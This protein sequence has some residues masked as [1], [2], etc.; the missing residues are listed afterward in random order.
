MQ[1]D[2]VVPKVVARSLW[3]TPCYLWQFSPSARDFS[4]LASL[5]LG[6]IPSAR[7][8]LLL[9]RLQLDLVLS[10]KHKSFLEAWQVYM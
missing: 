2:S 5:V 3:Q 9:G 1:N 7:G 10:M 8:G 4:Q 6:R